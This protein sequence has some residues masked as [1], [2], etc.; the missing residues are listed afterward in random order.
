MK[1]REQAIKEHEERDRDLGVK[2]KAKKEDSQPKK[3][4]S[5]SKKEDSQ[6][7]K[8]SGN[9]KEQQQQATQPAT[10]PSSGSKP[11]KSIH[12]PGHAQ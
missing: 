1:Q 5:Q 3:G 10:M 12:A 4:E 2:T 11:D 8:K 7:K 6:P 9:E